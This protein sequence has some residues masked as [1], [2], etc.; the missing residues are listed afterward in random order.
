[1]TYDPDRFDEALERLLEEDPSQ[2]EDQDLDPLLRLSLQLRDRLEPVAPDP[3][4]RDRLKAELLQKAADNVR[5]FPTTARIAPD[6][7][8]S[9]WR[10]ARRALAAL[11]IA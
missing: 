7:P 8:V 4:F 1:M 3:R 11:A 9:R 10:R 6:S 5:P 2:R